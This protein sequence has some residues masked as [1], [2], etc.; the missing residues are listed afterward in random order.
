MINRAASVMQESGNIQAI[1]L[2]GLVISWVKSKKAG[3]FKKNSY[4]CD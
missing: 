1:E 2:Q 4:L 3:G